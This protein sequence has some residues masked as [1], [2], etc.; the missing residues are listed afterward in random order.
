VIRSTLLIA[1]LAG[2]G[3]ASCA[4]A[5]DASGLATDREVIAYVQ[6]NWDGYSAR[7]AYLAGRPQAANTLLNVSDVEC[8]SDDE[9][10]ACTFTTKVRFADGLEAAPTVEGMFGRETDGSLVRLIQVRGPD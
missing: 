1:G 3:L 7:A 5:P 6:Q 4:S 9:L 2:I 8:R 10:I